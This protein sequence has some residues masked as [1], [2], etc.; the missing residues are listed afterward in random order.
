MYSL[1]VAAATLLAVLAVHV[2]RQI[3]PLGGYNMSL[4]F[5][6]TM[7]VIGSNVLLLVYAIFSFRK[8]F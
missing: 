6:A 2:E 3:D 4:E 1:A 5:P 7:L 8:D